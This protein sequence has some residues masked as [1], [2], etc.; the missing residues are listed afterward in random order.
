MEFLNL[1]NKFDVLL[2]NDTITKEVYSI[3]PFLPS[4]LSDYEGSNTDIWAICEKNSTMD[5]KQIKYKSRAND[6]PSIKNTLNRIM[7]DKLSLKHQPINK[8]YERLFNNNYYT[9]LSKIEKNEDLKVILDDE[10]NTTEY[11]E[12]RILELSVK[13]D[14]LIQVAQEEFRKD[15]HYENEINKL[16]EYI[17]QIKK[18]NETIKS[19]NSWKITKPLRYITNKLK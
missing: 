3:N 14:E 7:E 13:I 6:I 2:V 18:E 16:N 10:N 19:S 17:N 12:N 11:L 9:D 15:S 1:C 5:N 4:K 8:T